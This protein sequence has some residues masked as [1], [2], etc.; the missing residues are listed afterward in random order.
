MCNYAYLLEYPP[1]AALIQGVPGGKVIEQVHVLRAPVRHD[2]EL[3]VVLKPINLGSFK[4]EN[5]VFLSH[6]LDSVMRRGLK[7]AE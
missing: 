4:L 3:V 5:Y 1:R 6:K 7:I 2:N